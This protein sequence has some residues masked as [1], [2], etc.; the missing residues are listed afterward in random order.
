MYKTKR[1][2]SVWGH[3]HVGTSSSSHLS[4]SVHLCLLARNTALF[5]V[6]RAKVILQVTPAKSAI[7]RPSFIQS[8]VLPLSSPTCISVS[9]GNGPFCINDIDSRTKPRDSCSRP[10]PLAYA[11]N[12]LQTRLAAHDHYKRRRILTDDSFHSMSGGTTS[13]VRH[14]NPSIPKT[15]RCGG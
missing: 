10:R 7:T 12:Q 13:G 9:L 4:R 5:R 14:S 11:T 1:I 3:P 2:S 6:Q 8:T 15:N